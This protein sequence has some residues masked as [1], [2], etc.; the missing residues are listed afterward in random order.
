VI[1]PDAEATCTA[2]TEDAKDSWLHR[3]I[4]ELKAAEVWTIALTPNYNAS[5]R[6][7]FHVD[8]TPGS[9]FITRARGG[10]D[11]GPDDE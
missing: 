6:D 1:D 3:L 4:C 7:H 8:L 5:H 10:L 2:G 9:D 11:V